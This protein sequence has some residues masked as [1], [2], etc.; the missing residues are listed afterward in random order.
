MVELM[1]SWRLGNALPPATEIDRQLKSDGRLRRVAFDSTQLGAWDTSLLAFVVRIIRSG[2]A[3]GI[4]IDSS[5]LPEGVQHLLR[6]VESKPSRSTSEAVSRW[7]AMLHNLGTATLS[8]FEA[9][10]S[11]FDFVGLTVLAFLKLLTGRA[12]MRFSDLMFQVQA[13]GVQALGILSLISFLVGTILAFMGAVQLRQ[14][15]A[16]I[17]IADLVGIG[18]ARDMGAMMTAIIM[19]GRTGA[20]YAA[21]LGSMKV[22]EEIDAL[23]TMGISPIEF[24]VLPRLIA[25]VMMMPLLCLYADF[26]GM[27][28]GSAVAATVL[29]ISF[30]SYFGRTAA[31]VSLVSFLGGLFKATIYGVLVAVAGCWRGFEAQAGSSAV[32][33]A[34]T[35]AVVDSIVWVVTAC[36]LFAVIFN[37]M[38]L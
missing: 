37:V 34:A 4:E 11:L 19:A 2:S 18:I 1:G 24:L 7:R 25:L 6:L 15:G 3:R 12:R 20:A 35:A 36:G 38:H 9:G 27:L 32:G 33:E 10:L 26:L 8:F 17:Y 21:E 16:S 29:N 14:F 30:V 5:G 13:C 22:S 31:A 28:G 23:S